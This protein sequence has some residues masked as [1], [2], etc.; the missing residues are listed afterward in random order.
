MAVPDVAPREALELHNDTG[1]GH[2]IDPDRVFPTELTG[3]QGDCRPGEHDLAGELINVEIERPAIQ[4]LEAH[5]VQV[6][7][8]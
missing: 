1:H 5:Q 3:R 4:H 6:D 8:M 2:G 7:G